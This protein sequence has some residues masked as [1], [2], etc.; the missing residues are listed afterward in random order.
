MAKQVVLELEA[1]QMVK[2]V[3]T[4]VGT[5]AELVVLDQLVVQAV[6]DRL[7]VRD[8]LEVQAVLDRL[9]N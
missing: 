9:V 2:L 6:L 5:L 4:M 3:E 8:Q 7:E 1:D